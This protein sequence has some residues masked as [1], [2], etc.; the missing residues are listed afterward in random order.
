M[1]I[2]NDEV[3]LEVATEDDVKM[4]ASRFGTLVECVADV[5]EAR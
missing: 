3:F 2:W 5:D 1:E 4:V